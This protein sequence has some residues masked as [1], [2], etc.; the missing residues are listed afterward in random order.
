[1]NAMHIKLCLLGKNK[2]PH[3]SP[4]ELSC[5]HQLTMKVVIPIKSLLL[6]NVQAPNIT[7]VQLYSFLFSPQDIT[8]NQCNEKD[9]RFQKL[10][11]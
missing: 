10:I 1:M 9:S 6:E 11:S 4:K 2:A 5:I 8:S 7:F 3:R